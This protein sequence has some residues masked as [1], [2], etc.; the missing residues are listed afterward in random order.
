[1]AATRMTA[2]GTG[3]RLEGHTSMAIFLKR[4]IPEAESW[5]IVPQVEFKL[6][7]EKDRVLVSILTRSESETA[8]FQNFTQEVERTLKPQ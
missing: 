6:L 3:W 7:F 8:I 4:V 1:M 5:G 2:Y